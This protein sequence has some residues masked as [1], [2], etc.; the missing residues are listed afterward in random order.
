MVID[1][2]QWLDYLDSHIACLAAKGSWLW[3]QPRMVVSF[4]IRDS[5]FFSGV[6][7]R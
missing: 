5:L 6:T 7:R 2:F 3:A 1:S 4:I